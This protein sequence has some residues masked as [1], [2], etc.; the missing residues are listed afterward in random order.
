MPKTPE[1]LL[2]GLA[3][4]EGPRWRDGRLYFSDMH[5]HEVVAMAPDG[6]RETVVSAD[7]PVSGLGWL[8]DG[9]ML[10]VSMN[11]RRLLRREPDGRLVLHGDLSGIATF[12]CND[13]VVDAKGRA[14]VGNFGW[15]IFSDDERKPAHMARVDPDGRVSVAA[16]D[17][18]FPNG[19][20]ITDDGGTLIVGETFA[21]RMTAFDVAG[22]GSLSNR[23]LWAELPAD[24]VPDGCCL[25]AE[26]A[27]WVASPS[28]NEAIRIFEGGRV[29]E[30]I[31]AD[32]GVYA[33]MLGGADRRTLYLLTSKGSEPE[34][35]KAERSGRIEAV[36][37]D[38]PGAGRP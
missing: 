15:N 34:Q 9:R 22:D 21:G 7:G 20:V 28:T 5:A 13:M 24:A 18:I 33:C 23:R 8:P 37:V 19:A 31:A 6:S 29:A 12:H 14:Y 35:C 16:D 27:I 17:L 26:G 36:E 1:P 30:R 10:I 4:P 25:D 38:I 2:D 11:D 3:F 32:R